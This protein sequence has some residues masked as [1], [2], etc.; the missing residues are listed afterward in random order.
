MTL[1]RAVDQAV[2]SINAAALRNPAPIAPAEPIHPKGTEEY[3]AYA[4]ALREALADPAAW[5]FLDI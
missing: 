1:S 2:A 3:E 5:S 4:K